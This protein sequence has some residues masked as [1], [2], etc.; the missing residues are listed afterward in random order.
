MPVIDEILNF[1]PNMINKNNR[2]I[3]LRLDE[4]DT[5]I[6]LRLDES[7]RNTS[8]QVRFVELSERIEQLEQL[9]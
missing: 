5:N 7:D 4:S 9:K 6:Q 8:N 2:N 3:Q 1:L